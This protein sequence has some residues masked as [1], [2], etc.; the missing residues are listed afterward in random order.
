M[1]KYVLSAM[2]L[3]AASISASAQFSLGIKGGVNYSKLHSDN[4]N[5]TS[6]A[7]YQPVCLPG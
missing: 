1:K 5:S 6:V 2:L 4:F 7:G 3:I